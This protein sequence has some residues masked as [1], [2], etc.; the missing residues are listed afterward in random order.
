MCG[1]TRCGSLRLTC[2][3][4]LSPRV[5]GN[6]NGA[7]FSLA[8]SRSI[9]AC[10]GEPQALS[11]TVQRTTVYPRVCGGTQMAQM[12]GEDDNGLSPRV[13]GNL[14]PTTRLRLTGRSI[15]ACAGEPRAER[16]NLPFPKVYPR[17]C[18]GT[19]P[20]RIIFILLKGLSPRVRGNLRS[21]AYTA[22]ADRSIPAC[23]GE[24]VP[25]LHSTIYSEVYP[26]VCG[27]TPRRSCYA[28][29]VRGLSPRVRG[30]PDSDRP[31]PPSER[32]I[33]ACAGEPARSRRRRRSAWVYPRV[34]G[35]TI[36]RQV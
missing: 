5:R 32:S 30:N 6:L 24:P 36:M 4:G 28:K 29:S 18:G 19:N 25:L 27:G 23:A 22:R 35:G 31:P 20:S 11:P 16:Q 26:R 3:I 14:S 34:C 15:P 7:L 21:A 8:S 1:G 17:V 10:A 13:R 33:P 2:T 9:P 12:E